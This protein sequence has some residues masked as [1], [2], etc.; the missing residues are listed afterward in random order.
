MRLNRALAAIATAAGLFA[1]AIALA[2][3]A[4]AS[5]AGCT[6]LVTGPYANSCGSEVNMYG[7]AFDV[8]QQGAWKGNRVIAYP[9]STTDR[10]TDFIALSTNGNPD[11]RVFFYAPDGKITNLVIVDPAG[12]YPGDSR[13]GLIL[14]PYIAGSKF[15]QF[16]GVNTQNTAGTQWTNIATGQ[17]VTP[18]GTRNQ[19][20][21]TP[22][23]TA[24]LSL[25]SYWGWNAN[26][27]D[28][29]PAG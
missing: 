29:V 19:I 21:T 13:D 17:V 25:G 11:E 23:A 8:F 1:G 20:V 28:P 6:G 18:M 16:T 22:A 9:N 3:P 2:V 15:Q 14:K 5:T 26:G 10:A 12:G 27:V 7:N 24:A 4:G